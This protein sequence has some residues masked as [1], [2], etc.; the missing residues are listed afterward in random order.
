MR[1]LSWNY[2]NPRLLL[3]MW[4]SSYGLPL[5]NEKKDYDIYNYHRLMRVTQALRHY[6]ADV[7]C[8]QEI[9]RDVEYGFTI[10]FHYFIAQQLG[11][12]VAAESYKG[13]PFRFDYP[14]N[15]KRQVLS[16]DTGVCILTKPEYQLTNIITRE[17]SSGVTSPFITGELI[18]P[19]QVINLS[20]V[21]IR[22]QNGQIRDPVIDY[23]RANAGID[24]DNGVIMG[25]FNGG[26]RPQQLVESGITV[27]NHPFPLNI[28]DQ[29]FYGN[30]LLNSQSYMS[31]EPLLTINANSQQ[32]AANW[33]LLQRGE[34]T[35]DHQCI[36]FDM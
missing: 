35:S 33:D 24:F 8:L 10:P 19:T 1:L 34:A 5:L 7:I 30:F 36:I 17:M 26:S 6:N 15:E 32:A 16:V 21:H 23:L 31:S 2:L 28:D 18:T 25:D 29:I 22:M 20:T 12:I 9:S 14:P 11:M 4:R 27:L 3:A 13:A